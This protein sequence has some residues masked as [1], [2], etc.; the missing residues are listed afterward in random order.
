[1]A[2][3]AMYVRSEHRCD[4]CKH[5]RFGVGL[6]HNWIRCH[7]WRVNREWH[8]LWESL[9]TSWIRSI[10]LSLC[11][12]ICLLFTRAVCRGRMCSFQ[13]MVLTNFRTLVPVIIAVTIREDAEHS[14]YAKSLWTKCW[15]AQ[16]IESVWRSYPTVHECVQLRVASANPIARFGVNYNATADAERIERMKPLTNVFQRQSIKVLE[17]IRNEVWRFIS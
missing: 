3:N 6:C 4:H 11:V 12:A 1:M 16:N 15:V 2:C 7:V 10:M 9:Q 13:G 14:S 17:Q 5:T 8:A